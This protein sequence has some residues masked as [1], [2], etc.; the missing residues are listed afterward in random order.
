MTGDRGMTERPLYATLH[1]CPNDQTVRAVF[2]GHWHYG[3]NFPAEAN[4]G[5]QVYAVP[6]SVHPQNRPVEFVVAKVKP[7][8][9]IFEPRD[10]LTGQSRT[11]NKPVEYFPVRGRF[12]N[13]RPPSDATATRPA[14]SSRPADL[15]A[16]GSRFVPRDVDWE[17]PVYETSFDDASVLKD[18]RLEGGW[19]MSVAEGNLVLENGPADASAEAKGRHLVCW[20]TRE[21][22]AN[23]L[24]EFTV[25]PEDRRRGLNIVFFNARGLKGESIFDPALALRDGTFGQY[26]SGDLNNYHTSYWAGD[27]SSA[28]L[29]KNKGFHLVA[30]GD[31][32]VYSAPAGAFQ[33]VRIYKHGRRIVLT[34]DDVVSIAYEDD[35]KAGGPPH[36]RSGWI[37]LRQMAH[38]HRC[39]Y[40]KLAV[41]PLKP[42]A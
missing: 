17:H 15:P 13:L 6:A 29:R 30:T 20:L 27:R 32:L 18:W 25:R 21:M 35:G 42:P 40:G 8:E 23:F 7:D 12:G 26:H 41:Y 24:L 2:G 28:N 3:Q 4:L 10:S 1:A 31:D 9:I 19:R 14:P 37:G 22:P 5:V 11:E 36:T 34:V 38:T 16:A 39:D 33:T